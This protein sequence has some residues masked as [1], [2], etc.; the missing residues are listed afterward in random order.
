MQILNIYIP[1]T[2]EKNNICSGWLRDLI[3]M[4]QKL[5]Y[6]QLALTLFYIFWD[7]KKEM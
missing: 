4:L 3:K 5:F 1:L 6:M 7:R 2:N